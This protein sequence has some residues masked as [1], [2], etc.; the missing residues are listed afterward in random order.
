MAVA[1]DSQFFTALPSIEV[2][3]KDDAELVWLVY[4]LKHDSAEKLRHLTL[5]GFK[6]GNDEKST[7]DR[8]LRCRM[9]DHA[10]LIRQEVALYDALAHSTLSE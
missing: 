3:E 9:S 5:T 7:S 6:A 10:G 2:V 8:S 1:V 4:D